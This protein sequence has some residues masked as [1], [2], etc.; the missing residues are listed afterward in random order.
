MT[1]F[2]LAE[3][4]ERFV[5]K[6]GQAGHKIGARQYV[7]EILLARFLPGYQAGTERLIERIVPRAALQV[8]AP[9]LHPASNVGVVR[10]PGL[11]IDHRG[12]S[13]GRSVLELFAYLVGYIFFRQRVAENYP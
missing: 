1:E 6:F 4:R 3:A 8:E 11:D 10:F 12:L 13:S 7:N 2:G 9:P 5:H